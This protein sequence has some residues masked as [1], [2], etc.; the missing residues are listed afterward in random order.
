[1]EL[2]PE[3]QRFA[4]GWGE[5]LIYPGRTRHGSQDWRRF[6]VI[7]VSS[8]NM[9]AY[10]AWLDRTGRLPG[11]RL[12]SELEWEHAARGADGRAYPGGDR[13]APDD[14]NYDETYT[15]PLMGLDEVGVHP[16][17]IGPFGVADMSGNAFEW[18]RTG[19]IYV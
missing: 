6:P 17:A 13:L 1:I 11:A 10:A 9:V 16:N 14:V 18:T 5:H 12:C 4:A 19:A 7:G 2:Q 3:H 15:R 8:D